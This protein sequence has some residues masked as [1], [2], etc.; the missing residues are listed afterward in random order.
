MYGPL[1]APSSMHFLTPPTSQWSSFT[2]RAFQS[3]FQPLDGDRTNAP[4]APADSREL[5]VRAWRLR[6]RRGASS[7]AM[8]VSA[9][10][11]RRRLRSTP[12]EGRRSITRA[13]RSSAT[14]PPSAPTEAFPW[15]S[16]P[17]RRGAAHPA[18][19]SSALPVHLRCY[20]AP[21][22]TPLQ[23]MFACGEM[24]NTLIRCGAHAYLEFKAV[25]ATFILL[26][27]KLLV[28]KR[29]RRD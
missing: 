4:P 13:C 14:P 29:R 5:L 25:E 22:D 1:A 8:A 26:D 17:R 18:V 20:R 2:P 16:Q 21:A 6:A 12:R 28:R 3:Y 9:G 19:D 7:P 23:A 27:G 10:L 24:I 15:T 11:L